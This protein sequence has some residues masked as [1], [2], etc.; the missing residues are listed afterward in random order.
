MSQTI[1]IVLI[2]A[3]VA[4]F[5]G[6]NAMTQYRYKLAVE[7]RQ[8][9]MKLT[10]SVSETEELLLNTVMLPMSDQLMGVLFRRLIDL[11]NQILDLMPEAK[12]IHIR[13]MSTEE[14]LESMGP[15]AA[16]RNG[17]VRMMAVPKSDLH[18]AALIKTIKK[19]RYVLLLESR[20]GN[21]DGADFIMMDKTQT[22]AMNHIFTEYKI[23][24]GIMAIK[25]NKL[26][27]ARQFLD[28][29][30]KTLNCEPLDEYVRNKI[31]QVEEL[32]RGINSDL[33]AIRAEFDG[34]RDIEDDEELGD[35]AG[36]LSDTKKKW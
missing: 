10:V 7:R 18:I 12:S 13:L 34:D 24:Q 21:L 16:E 32:L 20:S 15:I 25:E 26:G 11:F 2:F 27:S 3:F 29:A 1:I 30:L 36:Y 9:L 4:L 6:A 14:Q 31:E 5:I 8:L 33:A 22:S 35:L 17:A 19:I 23:N 28:K